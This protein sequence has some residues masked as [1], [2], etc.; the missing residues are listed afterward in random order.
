MNRKNFIKNKLFKV[1]ILVAV[2]GLL[3]FFNPYRYF[4]P[5]RNAISI[6]VYPFEKTLYFFSMKIRNGRELVS[7][8]GKIKEDNSRLVE[9]NNEL[10][11]QLVELED[12]RK[13]NDEL[14]KQL[15]LLPRENY[16]MVA[17]SIIGQNAVGANAW[18]LIDRGEKQG[19]KKGMAVIVSKGSLVGR[20]E[21]VSAG[22]AKINLITNPDNIIN[23]ETST[24]SRGVT[25]GDFGLGVVLDMVVS[26]DQL[27]P[28]DRLFTS[29][30][31]GDVPRGFFI[32][33]IKEAFTSSD[34]LFNGATIIPAVDFSKLKFVFVVT[35][36]R[37]SN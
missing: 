31:G 15:E 28:G 33:T 37:G 24:G 23:A 10:Y 35:N 30:I 1:I 34:G 11:S 4:S 25:R 13:E 32:G 22:A 36:S 5:V 20:V 19:I 14:R 12:L 9:E 27:N 26:T 7:S 16:Q 3:I 8:I 2:C 18:I 6:I 29:G 21:E 17:A